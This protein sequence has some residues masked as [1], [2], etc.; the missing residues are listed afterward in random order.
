LLEQVLGQRREL[1]ILRDYSE[2]LQVGEDG[3]AQLIPALV[4]QF[5]ALLQPAAQYLRRWTILA[6][7]DR[8]ARRQEKG[9][10]H[11]VPQVR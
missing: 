4:E 11:H 3:F 6:N 5:I 7:S 10:V 8:G 9:E 1:G 2:F